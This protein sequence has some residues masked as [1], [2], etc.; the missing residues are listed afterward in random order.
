MGSNPVAIHWYWSKGH[1]SIA[2]FCGRALTDRVCI[3]SLECMDLLGVV[4]SKVAPQTE[5]ILQSVAG[6]S[7]ICSKG[8][9]FVYGN[10][11]SHCSV[12][13]S[14]S[15]LM[16][17]CCPSRLLSITEVDCICAAILVVLSYSQPCL[18]RSVFCNSRACTRHLQP[19]SDLPLQQVMSILFVDPGW[20]FRGVQGFGIHSHGRESPYFVNASVL[21]LPE[22]RSACRL[23]TAVTI[24]YCFLMLMHSATDVGCSRGSKSSTML[25][26]D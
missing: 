5:S 4:V 26:V 11:G 25:S 12:C 20:W 23:C 9:F 8:R 14:R 6:S 1:P 15:F 17:P 7:H 19:S 22:P 3:F 24:T 21:T 10:C 13:I 2:C 18:V 16:Q